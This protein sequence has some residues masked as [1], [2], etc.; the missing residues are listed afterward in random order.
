MRE[1]LAALGLLLLALALTVAV[2]AG[3]WLGSG[4]STGSTDL[5]Q[6]SQ[7]LTLPGGSS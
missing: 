2:L 1:E 6:P 3:Q 4:A 5:P 7:T